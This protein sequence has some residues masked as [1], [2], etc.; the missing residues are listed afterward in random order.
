MVDGVDFVVDDVGGSGGFETDTLVLDCAGAEVELVVLLDE[1]DELDDDFDSVVLLWVV[2]SV[3]AALADVGADDWLVPSVATCSSRTGGWSGSPGR[4]APAANKAT[5]AAPRNA[6]TAIRNGAPRWSSTMYFY[7][8]NPDGS[9][10]TEKLPKV[11]LGE[12][13]TRFGHKKERT[14]GLEPATLTLAR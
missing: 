4:C 3:T 2:L 1:D 13:L 5:A 9:S 14:T 11:D 12:I 7:W 6:P 10:E 8:L